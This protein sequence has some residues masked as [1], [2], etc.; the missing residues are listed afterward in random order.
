VVECYFLYCISYR[1][2][3]WLVLLAIFMADL[4]SLLHQLATRDVRNYHWQV[5]LHFTLIL[6]YHRLWSHRSFTAKLPLRIALASM[7]T[8]GFQGSIRYFLSG[9][10][11]MTGGGFCGIVYTI[12]LPIRIQIPIQR[13]RAS[14]TVTSGGSLSLRNILH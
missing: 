9:V 13:T 10:L 14:S 6:G 7:G 3:M 2:I 11:L 4:V 1:R 5:P 12:D 8:L